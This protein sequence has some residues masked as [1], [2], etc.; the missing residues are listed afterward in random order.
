MT[1]QSDL[2]ARI[3]RLVLGALAR[4]ER[5][6]HADGTL[7]FCDVSG[8]T[9]L[10][11]RLAEQGKAGAE[12]LTL[13]LN[14]TFTDLLTAAFERGGDLLKFGGDALLLLF[15][16]DG[17]P[18]RACQAAFA[19][20]AALK[21]RGPVETGRGRVILRMS[22]GV[23]TGRFACFVPGTNQLEL[24][25]IGKDAS[26]VTDMETIAE[27]GEILLSPA[28]AA[29]VPPAWHGAP[30]EPG[31]LLRRAPITDV[32]AMPAPEPLDGME[33]CVPPA[34]LAR[35]EG[36]ADD[37]E[38]RHVAIGFVKVGHLDELVDTMAH[39]ELFR[40][41][42]LLVTATERHCATHGVTLLATDIASGGTKLILT[43][44]APDG[45]EDAEGRLLLVGRAILDE[46]LHLPLHIG[47]NAGHIYAGDVGA[48]F[49]RTYTV[50]GDAV[51]LA[52]RLMAKADDN[53]LLAHRPT[54]AAAGV[55]FEEETVEPFF[56]KGKSRPIEALYLGSRREGR[57]RALSEAPFIG[58]E[59]EL[60]A[61]LANVDDVRAGNGHCF[62]IVGEPGIGKSRLVDE[63]LR[64][65]DLPNVRITCEPFQAERAYFVSRLL[66]RAILRI[67]Q[68]ADE[69]EAG[70]WLTERIEDRLPHLLPVLPLLAL[71][72]DAEVAA[73]ETVELMAPQNRSGVLR[74]VVSEV[75]ATMLRDASVLV[76]EDANWV[77]DASASVLA[78]ALQE[79]E[80][81]SWLV[82]LTT[83]ASGGGLGS[84]LGFP[85]ARMELEPLSAEGTTSLVS[86]A[87]GE[88]VALSDDDLRAISSR[89]AGNPL[90][91]LELAAA[92]RD[93]GSVRGLPAT[94]EGLVA[95]RVDRLSASD[96]RVLRYAAVIGERFSPVMVREAFR[97]LVSVNDATWDR[98]KEFVVFERGDYRFAHDLVREVA[99]EGLPYA[100]RRELH[101]RVAQAIEREDPDRVDLL[102]LHFDQAHDRAA[103]W[104][105]ARLAGER[106]REKYANVE[107]AT[108]FDRA[109]ENS[110]QLGDVE[111]A[112][113]ARV[114]EALGDVCELA[115]QFDHA[116][117]AYAL[118]RRLMKDD[119][120]QPRLLL[121]EGHIRERTGKYEA[122]M[123]WYRRGRQATRVLEERLAAAERA[124]LAL[125]AAGIQ[126][127]QGRLREAVRWC[128]RALVDA[129]SSQDK[130]ALGHAYYLLDAALTDLGDPE[131]EHYRL[132]ALPVFEELGD[133]VGQANVLANLAVDAV[134]EGRW[135]EALELQQRCR[136]ARTAAGDVV[137]IANISHNQS[138]LLSDQGR[139]EEAEPL[140]REAR[141][142]WRA[143]R[144]PL[145]VAAATNCLGRVLTRSG[146]LDE[147]IALLEQA[148]SDF[149]A[150]G[151]HGWVVEAEC[152]LGEA[153]SYRRRWMDALARADVQLAEPGIQDNGPAHAF[154][155][156]LAG[157]CHARSGHEEEALVL[158]RRSVEVA[159]TVRNVYEIALGQYELGRI[160]TG[161]EAVAASARAVH[162]LDQLGVTG[163]E[164]VTPPE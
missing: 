99:Y 21:A 49:R 3:P 10:S 98:L 6:F 162:T 107:A 126:L 132:L 13:I 150:L 90:F 156:R 155:L 133:L 97:D 159:E 160:A 60:A 34:V 163:I 130:K 121:K 9:K 55:A 106:A 35:V 42:D 51:N 43:A 118:A 129:E 78:R 117:H 148:R 120:A 85:A 161:E 140:S 104:K 154:F 83:R 5:F 40:E 32:R 84:H 108:F 89:S 39:D 100:R 66:L 149:A 54:V 26:T 82:C 24:V 137:G 65:A 127:R 48:P 145:G 14:A 147:G 17:H 164:R 116:A 123:R 75:L 103:A 136:A 2:L 102:S 8:F 158:L 87:L 36:G 124:E 141:R 73:T 70:R 44:G 122:A 111:D 76:I 31:T 72:A 131:A 63:L 27:A 77:D 79:V 12:E 67:P 112:E 1:T 50:M 125:G 61:L 11:E 138:E 28:T 146:R 101:L 113:M 18:E 56:V 20:R 151:A 45:V 80:Q 57:G 15:Q 143:A 4:G 139:L 38:H 37:S 105:Y 7:V 81:R 25:V 94:L 74:E 91:M 47:I 69:Q 153:E 46:H 30:K 23:H 33:R 16:G 68:E 135:M 88:D 119:E 95:S 19:M 71:A 152:R 53:R 92:V 109:L 62:E 134:W 115:G 22:Q 142:I 64:V 59:H 110:R 157:V 86:A 29:L 96:R 52:A 128:R 114:A 58:R 144:Y 41:L 93:A